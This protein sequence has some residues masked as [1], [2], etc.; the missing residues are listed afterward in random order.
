MIKRKR[1]WQHKVKP[2]D[3]LDGTSRRD[4]AENLELRKKDEQHIT[5]KLIPLRTP[6]ERIKHLDETRT[7]IMLCVSFTNINWW[8]ATDFAYY[9][10]SWE[11]MI[12]ER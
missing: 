7:I 8:Q 3:D 10:F 4:N 11:K 12:K 6:A 5:E 1:S 9:L 2:C